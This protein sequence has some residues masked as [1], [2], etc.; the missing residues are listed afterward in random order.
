MEVKELDASTPARLGG[1]ELSAEL[2]RGGMGSV[3]LGRRSGAGGFHK[4]VAIK[5]VHPHLASDANFTSMFLDEARIA[6]H[7]QHPNVAQ[8]FELAQ[9]GDEHLLIMEYL[10]GVNLSDLLK[11]REQG[12]GVDVAMHIIAEAARG[13]HAAHVAED[14]RGQPLCL[15]H[16]DVT[17]Q[18]IFLT[19]D[20]RI[21]LTDFGVARAEGRIVETQSGWLKGKAAYMSPEQ[22]QGDPIDGRL[23]I[24]ALGVVFWEL[25][26]RRRLFRRKSQAEAMM[27]I[28]TGDVVPPSTHN[29]NVDEALDA[30]VMKALA[31][32]PADRFQTADA[33]ARALR[34]LSRSLNAHV[35]TIDVASAIKTLLPEA[36]ESRDALLKTPASALPPPEGEESESGVKPAGQPAADGADEKQTGT[37]KSPVMN[38]T[39]SPTTGDSAAEQSHPAVRAEPRVADRGE[40]SEPK[41]PPVGWWVAAAL[42]F[43]ASIGLG[44]VF[45]LPDD[46]DSDATTTTPSG[47]S[48]AVQFESEPSGARVRIDGIWQDGRTPLRVDDLAP[49]THEIEVGLE[50]H[51]A[52][53][54]SIDVNST[55]RNV[56][57]ELEPYAEPVAVETSDATAQEVAVREPAET[58]TE[59]E[60]ARVD[61]APQNN[62][63]PMVDRR[64][65]VRERASMERAEPAGSAYLNLITVPSVTVYLRGRAIGRTPMRRGEIPSGRTTLELRPAEGPSQSITVNAEPGET[66]AVP[67]VVLAD[68]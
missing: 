52:W 27:A 26:T 28:V 16:R 44:V 58:E 25:L 3:Y 13:L 10:H 45:A 46:S 57:A 21:K 17:P 60:P 61:D 65:R 24:F 33:M 49:G 42:A 34:D 11:S 68:Q 18:N 43:A 2:G 47:E 40:D 14:E 29:P 23:D 37:L 56:H 1:Y 8:V 9:D 59:T 63:V 39:P 12:V 62:P 38:R 6:A 35:D 54:A 48:L 19:F 55:N 66:V 5:R 36:R 15:V 32:S 22:L 41:R 20:G 64:P 67:R 51:R 31:P 30:I 50:E 7:I 53:I 4:W